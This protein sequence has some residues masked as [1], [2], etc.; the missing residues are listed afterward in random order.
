M[1]VPRIGGAFSRRGEG[2]RESLR[3]NRRRRAQVR[4]LRRES[5]SI[6]S[7]LFRRA[8]L[9]HLRIS[10]RASSSPRLSSDAS[11]RLCG[12]RRVVA[13]QHTELSSCSV[14]SRAGT[15]LCAQSGLG[16]FGRTERRILP[17]RRQTPAFR[18]SEACAYEEVSAHVSV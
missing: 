5:L 17:F 14:P 4:G 15:E 3:Q 16:S 2:G 11:S 7:G 1:R 6:L 13:P 18:K 12:K 8:N 10:P 9:R